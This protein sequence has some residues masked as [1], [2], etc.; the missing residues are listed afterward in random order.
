MASTFGPGRTNLTRSFGARWKQ[1]SK[2]GQTN[3]TAVKFVRTG[4]R[5]WGGRRD[6]AQMDTLDWSF[7][8]DL[9]VRLCLA[10]T[11]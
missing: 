11:S 8:G 3:N 4:A 7:D 5:V 6:G 2:A 1:W 10:P 9:P